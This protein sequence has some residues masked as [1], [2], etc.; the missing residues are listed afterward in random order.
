[1]SA[2]TSD[3]AANAAATSEMEGVAARRVALEVLARVEDEGAY[4]NLILSKILDGSGLGQQD[5]G[6][7]TDLV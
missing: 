2:S 5:R 3:R 7:A 4:S 1:M 6:F